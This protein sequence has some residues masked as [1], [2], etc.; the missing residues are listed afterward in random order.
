MK[1]RDFLRLLPMGAVATMP[2]MQPARAQ[3]LW[4]M[5]NQSRTLTDA[6]REANS[7][8]AIEAIDTVEPILS[9]DTVN[10][11]HMAI[12]QYEPFVARGGW[13]QVPQETYGVTMGV[14]RD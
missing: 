2:M 1:R 6:E 10:N 7:A 12:A 14:A 5:M 9:Y 8:A 13:E 4:D 11:L 3:S